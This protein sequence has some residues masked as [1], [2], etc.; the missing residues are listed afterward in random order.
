MKKNL[1]YFLLLSTVFLYSCAS[2]KST[3]YFNNLAD[4]VLSTH[5]NMAK[6]T[7]PVIQKD[8]ILAITIQTIDPNTSSAN[9]Q[10]PTTANTGGIQAQQNISG[11]LVDNDGMI[12]LPMI[13]KLK[14]G[15][16]NTYE[17]K[18]L[19]V[20][21][22]SKYLKDPV[23]QV[24]FANYRITVIGEVSKPATFTVPSEKVSI[25]DLLGM[26]GDLTIYGRRDNIMLIR[27]HG[28]KKEIARLNLSSSDIMESPYFY[29]KQND[30]IYVE[31]NKA[32]MSVNN[33]E[34]FRIL[35][36]TLSI[37]SLGIVILTRF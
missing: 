5:V 30:V 35:S 9:M 12:E 22:A 10:M 8:D 32:K 14:L 34:R 20:E 31:P 19:I 23:V 3:V 25:L 1:K 27:D 7:E 17:A 18:K 28:D 11:Y 36:A 2:K 15:G 33:T 24:R 21:K 4:T 16:L 6:F 26:A 37:I 29:L 13:G